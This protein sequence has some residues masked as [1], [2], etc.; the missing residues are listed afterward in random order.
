MEDIRMAADVLRTVYDRTQGRDGFVSLEVSPYLAFD[1]AATMAEARRLHAAVSRPNVMIKVPGTPAGVPAIKQLVGQG[2]N[3]N[4]TLLFSNAAYEAVADAYM[5]GVEELLARGGDPTRV[6]S[7]ASFFVSRIDSMVDAMLQSRIEEAKSADEKTKLKALQGKVAIANAKMAYQIYKK[8]VAGPRWQS[9]ARRGAR[10]QRLLWASTS[11]KNPAYRDVVYVEELIGADTVDTMPAQTLTAFR[12]H[13]RVRPSLEEDLEGARA[14]LASL[15]E[16]DISLE[17]VTARLLDDA[18]KLFADPFDKLLGAI[19]RRRV[20]HLGGEL[21]TQTVA[22]PVELASSVRAASE[23]WRASGKVRRLWQRDPSLW[24]GQDEGGWMGW[25]DIVEDTLARGSELESLAKDVQAGGF[26]HVVLMGMGG[27]SLAPE[28]LASGFGAVRGWPELLV[29]DSTDPGQ[30]AT[31]EKKL[32]LKRTLFIVASKSGTTLEPNLFK[33]YFLSRVKEAVGEKEA[34]KR[35]VAITDP[36]SKM[37]HV[38]EADGFRRVLLGRASIGGRYSALSCFGMA[39]AAAAGIDVR[40]LLTR[41]ALMV[42]SC[43]GS[44]PPEENPGVT[45]GLVLGVLA[46]TGRDKLTILTSPGLAGFGAW[47]EQL[48][49]ESTGKSGKGIVPVDQEWLAPPSAYG[50]DRVFVHLRLGA[51]VDAAQDAALAALEKAGQPVVRICVKDAYAIGQEFFRWEIATAVAGSVI[52]IHPFDQPDVEASKVVT[53]KLTAEYEKAGALPPET[54]ALKSEGLWLYTDSKNAAVLSRMAGTD[55]TLAGWLR[56]HLSRIQPG[57]YFGLLAYLEMNEWHEVQL[58]AFRHAVRDAKKVATCLGFGPRFLHSTGQAYK[59]G[60]N[61][62]VFLQVTCDD[63]RDVQVPGR[64][65][66]FGAV[67]AAQARG[68]FDV[69]AERGRRL[70]RVHLGADV[71]AGLTTLQAAL[72]TALA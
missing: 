5:A 63:A 28:V 34:G 22:L 41:A 25:L 2:I 39:P 44:V 56:A 31:L 50:N 11:T 66:S 29:L 33:D 61:T 70:L 18:V 45:L 16:H 6:A 3:V 8:L 67:K 14:V 69:L 48:V 58:Q 26:A 24:T 30:V 62:G 38:A 27:S 47:L 4:V 60:P 59:G 15:E 1:T 42:R 72:E 53:R 10:P 65:Y 23:E 19:E 43:A 71:Q 40:R 32:D 51:E 12:E 46:K 20:K 54:P 64:G 35:F 13:G 68:D 52:G 37:Q 36:S 9:L 7:V 55:R 17:N 21:D 57:D 49:A